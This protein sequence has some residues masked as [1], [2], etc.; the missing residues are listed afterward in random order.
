M[1]DGSDLEFEPVPARSDVRVSKKFKTPDD[2]QI[3]V[4]HT[5][6]GDAILTR[7][8]DGEGL[9]DSVTVTGD[10]ETIS[11]AK[12]SFWGRV[13][14]KVKGAV[15]AVVDAVTGSGCKLGASGKVDKDGNLIRFSIWVE[16]SA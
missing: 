13:W 3:R 5:V 14:R 12:K 8:G 6:G 2:D 4:I 15:G 16:C 9:L 10:P 11:Q 7:A 1:Q